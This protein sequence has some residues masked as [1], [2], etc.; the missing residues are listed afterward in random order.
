[1]KLCLNSD[2]CFLNNAFWFW[3][4]Q[5]KLIP[6]K[7]PPAQETYSGLSH[8]G[9]G[10]GSNGDGKARDYSPNIVPEVIDLVQKSHKARPYIFKKKAPYPGAYPLNF[11][12]YQLA[13]HHHVLNNA[14]NLTPAELFNDC[15]I[16][17]KCIAQEFPSH[18]FDEEGYREDSP[19]AQSRP[20]CCTRRVSSTRYSSRR[21]KL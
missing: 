20:H 6:S 11:S 15:R 13:S 9:L 12:P 8:S 14:V 19:K 10:V 17:K 5:M 7:E 3:K 16:L 2:L 1:V 18:Y 4:P 21:Q